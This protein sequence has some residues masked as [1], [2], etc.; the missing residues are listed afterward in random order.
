MDGTVAIRWVGAAEDGWLE[1][2]DQRAL[3]GDE[4]WVACRSP[5]EVIE[6]IR[7]MVVR[8]APAIGLAGAYGA[9][10][11]A[12]TGPAFSGWLDALAAARPT[13]IH[14]AWAIDRTRRRAASEGPDAAALL[15]EAEAIRAEDVAANRRMGALGASLLPGRVRVLT[16]CNTGS[17]ATAGYGT[18]LGVIRALHA[19]GRLVRAFAGETR[20][21][22]QGA[23]L[24]MWEMMRERIPCTLLT[25][26]MAAALMRAG[27][28]DAVVVGADR[29]ARNGDTANKIGTYSLA[30]LAAHHRLP[31]VVVAPRATFDPQAATGGDLPIEQ[32]AADEVT[33]WRNVAAAPSGAD[34]WNPSFD[35]TP[36]ELITAIVTEEGVVHRRGHGASARA[37]IQ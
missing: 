23:R 27:E 28:V 19:E 32:R 4:A 11:A 9:V 30:V 25:D 36:G 2:L 22:L 13:A 16:H 7:A 29:I 18:A 1:L 17:L 3:P 37:Q 12:R 24:T 8:G 35:V 10:L 20:P 15:A 21:L 14:L 31:F 33:R 26:G 6:A 5:A 34:A